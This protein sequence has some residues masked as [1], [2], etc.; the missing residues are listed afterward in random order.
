MNERRTS[1]H[2]SVVAGMNGLLR[3]KNAGTGDSSLSRLFVRQQDHL[4]SRYPDHPY[5]IPSGAPAESRD[6]V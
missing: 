6:L 3:M 4:G 2:H 1:H 5:V